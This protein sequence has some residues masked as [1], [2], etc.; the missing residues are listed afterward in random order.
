MEYIILKVNMD[1]D[2]DMEQLN[3]L[4]SQGWK[5]HHVT[6]RVNDFIYHLCRDKIN[7]CDSHYNTCDCKDPLCQGI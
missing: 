5:C 7:D 2:E 4:G 1:H 6:E 3:I